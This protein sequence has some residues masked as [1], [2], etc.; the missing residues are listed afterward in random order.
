MRVLERAEI[1]ALLVAAH[2]TY[3]PLLATAVFTGLRRAGA[4]EGRAR[5]SL[6]RVP[7]PRCRDPTRKTTPMT[8]ARTAI[9]IRICM[10]R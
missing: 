7:A 1:G 10:G 4:A 6:V 2:P 5:P 3:R 9:V 8:T